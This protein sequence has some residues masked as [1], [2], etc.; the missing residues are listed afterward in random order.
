MTKRNR[1][2]AFAALLAIVMAFTC[3]TFS[4]QM[5]AAEAEH[6]AAEAYELDVPQGYNA[7]DYAKLRAFLEQEDENGIKN[8]QKISGNYDPNDISTW[9]MGIY[10]ESYSSSMWKP[11]DGELRLYD[12]SLWLYDDDWNRITLHGELDFADC[13][14]LVTVWGSENGFTAADFSG[15]SSLEFVYLEKCA[16][17]SLNLCGCPRVMSLDCSDNN[18]TELR[19]FESEADVSAVAL[20]F[21]DCSGNSIPS[22]PLSAFPQLHSLY[23]SYN[24]LGE[25]DLSENPLLFNLSCAGCELSEL[26]IEHL[27]LDGLNCSNNSLSELVFHPE[28][29]PYEMNI[30]YNRIAELE[31]PEN[32]ENLYTLFAEHNQLTSLDLSGASTLYELNL[33]GNPLTL[34]LLDTPSIPIKRL[35]AASITEGLEPAGSVSLAWFSYERYD[36][37]E[38]YHYW[39]DVHTAT[40]QDEFV[41]GF[42]GWRDTDG[43][44]IYGFTDIYLDDHSLPDVLI[45]MFR[46][47]LPGDVNFDG[48]VN[49]IDATL[50]LRYV[51]GDAGWSELNPQAADMNGDHTTDMRDA[52]LIL[53]VALSQNGGQTPLE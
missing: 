48:E 34:L 35:E 17:S 31:L 33:I 29:N 40:A 39:I 50:T 27:L 4:A 21:L 11:V 5:L 49:M 52:L 22:L 37:E 47:R 7:N 38:G 28:A 42:Q 23:C 10:G 51:L 9:D 19:F 25:L 15:C 13:T 41:Y 53:R 43:N 14:E 45:A 32:I 18:L 30:S 26:N 20:E 6:A 16:L 2:S 44:A 24:P 36:E 8:G 3:I 1:K 12:L 46:G